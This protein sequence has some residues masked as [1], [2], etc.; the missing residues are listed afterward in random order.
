MWSRKWSKLVTSSLPE[1]PI[2]KLST[3]CSAEVRLSVQGGY[4]ALY[5]CCNAL[6]YF[7]VNWADEW[8]GV[9]ISKVGIQRAVLLQENCTVLQCADWR[10][11]ENWPVHCVALHRMRSAR[12][13]LAGWW[14]VDR[15]C[16]GRIFSRF[17]PHLPWFAQVCS[18]LYP[19]FVPRPEPQSRSC[20]V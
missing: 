16:D 11:I 2:S 17:N 15:I 4:G 18:T 8:S 5:S 6:N 1:V 12:L 20:E 14:E 19:H 3:L 10:F 7:L 13:V 9:S